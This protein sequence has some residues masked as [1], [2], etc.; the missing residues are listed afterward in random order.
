MDY[1]SSNFGELNV[2]GKYD[3]AALR[4]GYAGKVETK[5]GKL[6]EVG[7]SLSSLEKKLK[8]KRAKIKKKIEESAEVA[9]LSKE[10]E[11]H[12]LKTFEFCTDENAGASLECNRHDE[13]TSLT[14]ITQSIIKNYKDSYRLSN[15][16]NG[17]S[18]FNVGRQ[19]ISY[20]LSRYN[21]FEKIRAVFEEWESYVQ[22]LGLPVMTSGCSPQHY[23]DPGLVHICN[24]IRDRIVAAKNAGEFF[25]EILKTPDHTC[26]L[27]KEQGSNKI[28]ELRKLHEIYEN[29]R[30]LF[31]SVPTTCF[32]STVKE[33]VENE[34]IKLY[35][36]S[37]GGKFLNGIRDYAPNFKSTY[38]R[39]VFGTWIDKI[40]AMKGI[41]QRYS[42]MTANVGSLNF[43]S[44]PTL[45]KEITS[46]I[47]HLIIQ[48]PLQ[49]PV[50]FQMEDGL[51]A[52]VPYSIDNT[53]VIKTED[54]PMAFSWARDF[55]S[56]DDRPAP[57][58]RAVLLENAKKFD[59]IIGKSA[60][61]EAR[62]LINMYSV[63]RISDSD[64]YENKTIKSFTSGGISFGATE[65]NQF[66]L[67]VIESL[68]SIKFLK[69]QGKE[70]V[71]K[72]IEKRTKVPEGS[73]EGPD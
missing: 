3:V 33:I 60:P 68:N 15:F 30:Q 36:H 27:T 14:E 48:T 29:N 24:M 43:L 37:E 32:N 47:S 55:L 17:R 58:L 73:P 22:F 67:A 26:A 53:Y 63:R 69:E 70:K 34:D 1:V 56:I 61:K 46:Y 28:S 8:E 71:A 64:T 13:G 10:L 62:D 11:D 40:L 31:D 50:P 19:M 51:L 42:S 25:L 54:L 52:I 23:Q 4:Y 39:A 21:S 65:D 5:S 45:G 7:K 20:L 16:R 2:L 12:T 9:A 6:I 38:D 41:V 66:A 35:V 44:H 49:N 59:L 18:V 72:I 57:R